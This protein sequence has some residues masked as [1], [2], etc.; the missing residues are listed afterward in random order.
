MFRSPRGQF[1]FWP[2]DFSQFAELQIETEEAG[3]K[4]ESFPLPHPQSNAI[5][6]SLAG[7]D[8]KQT[9]VRPETLER[10]AVA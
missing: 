4:Q 3:E 5:G 6:F 2:N 7:P 10:D 8:G 1:A 9:A